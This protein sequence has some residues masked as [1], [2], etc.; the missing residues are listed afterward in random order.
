MHLAFFQSI[1]V[2]WFAYNDQLFGED[3][4][5]NLIGGIGDDLLV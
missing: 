4:N 1:D 5:D 2:R 3:G